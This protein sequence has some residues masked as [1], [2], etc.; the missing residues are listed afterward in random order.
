M[1]YFGA[2]AVGAFVV[3]AIRYFVMIEQARRAIRSKRV[4]TVPCVLP[5]WGQALEFGK[6]R[7]ALFKRCQ[8]AYGRV[9]K[10][11]LA[12]T[13]MIVVCDADLWKLMLR[14]KETTDGMEDVFAESIANFWSPVMSKG[15][16]YAAQSCPR[17]MREIRTEIQS[18]THLSDLTKRA[19]A[20][21]GALS[22]DWHG[23]TLS[24]RFASSLAIFRASVA[25][26]YGPSRVSELCD[27]D[28]FRKDMLTFDWGLSAKAQGL[29]AWL[30]PEVAASQEA[31]KR[32]VLG[33]RQAIRTSHEKSAIIA[34][35]EQRITER[36]QA[37][38]AVEGDADAGVIVLLWAAI[39]NT[40]N[41]A[42]YMM[43]YVARDPEVAAR[44]RAEALAVAEQDGSLSLAALGKLPLTDS[45]IN[46]SLRLHGGGATARRTGDA[47][48]E[49]MITK[50]T[51]ASE[52]SAT[53]EL[54]DVPA[55]TQIFG[56]MGAML[57][58]ERRFANADEFV[59]TRFLSASKEDAA[60]AELV[61]GGGSHM[62]PGR[63]F[64]RNELRAFLTGICMRFDM[65]C[66]KKTAPKQR[67]D[68]LNSLVQA[69]I[70][71]AQITFRQIEK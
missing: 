7:N 26:L 33:R 50:S 31:I 46:E 21:L 63:F 17:H 57:R 58:D 24:L 69:P 37:G 67:N 4:P 25:A 44:I 8:A 61:F 23:K 42:F 70:E 16:A 10:L 71:D 56:F 6:D 5:W 30:S 9:F 43:Y 65:T 35:V 68:E 59:A 52:S 22:N 39:V 32:V 38:V 19:Q 36:E 48:V 64:V 47:P 3:L 15:E 11:T 60:L 54:H 51:L 55:R 62:C 66:D 1:I 45:V 49:R 13:S 14:T 20:E 27:D 40:F 12:G 41:A 18:S 2:I 34:G 28:E 53:I 29:P